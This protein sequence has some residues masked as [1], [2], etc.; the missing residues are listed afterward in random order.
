MAHYK[1]A[2]L[3]GSNRRESLNRELAH[4]LAKLAGDKLAFTFVR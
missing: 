2:V 1:V 3:V 4:A